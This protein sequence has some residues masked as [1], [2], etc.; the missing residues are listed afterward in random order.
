M[1]NLAFVFAFVLL[2]L[3]LPASA[4]DISTTAPAPTLEKQIEGPPPPIELIKIL[5][6]YCSTI[7]G[8]CSPNGSTTPCTDICSNQLSCTCYNHLWYCNLEC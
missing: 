7:Q 6:P 1:K 4:A 5:L 3:A 2:A 8:S